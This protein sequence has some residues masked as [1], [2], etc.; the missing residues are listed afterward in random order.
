MGIHPCD[1]CKYSIC[2]CAIN[3]VNYLTKYSFGA[4]IY[5]SALVLPQ[6]YMRVRAHTQE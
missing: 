5:M 2:L 1:F 6:K 3:I 4:P